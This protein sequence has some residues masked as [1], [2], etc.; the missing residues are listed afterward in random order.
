MK[1]EKNRIL[2]SMVLWGGEWYHPCE[3]WKKL[4]QEFG[5]SHVRTIVC[6]SD[7]AF[8]PDSISPAAGKIIAKVCAQVKADEALFA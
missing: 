6:N 4:C 1:P 8:T 5:E 2:E 7:R 3:E